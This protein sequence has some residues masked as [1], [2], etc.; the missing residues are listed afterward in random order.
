M[1]IDTRPSRVNAIC[2]LLAALAAAALVGLGARVA[3]LGAA[4]GVVA[5]TAGLVTRSR[6]WLSVGAL[7][8][9]AGVLVASLLDV[10]VAKVV[11][12]GALTLVAWDL[13]ENA[14]GLGTQVGRR[15]STARVEVVRVGV[16]AVVG[17]V[18]AGLALLVRSPF[19]SLPLSSLV[20]GLAAA[21]VLF[22]ALRT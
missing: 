18:A 8:L 6:S 20:V 16:S 3:L 5:L 14:I 4:T 9:L 13:A 19:G 7:G 10:T 1:T 12:G 21:L 11:V 15:A 22:A 17:T 2:A